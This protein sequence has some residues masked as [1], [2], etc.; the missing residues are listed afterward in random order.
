[1]LLL[2]ARNQLGAAL[3]AE[4]TGPALGAV[5]AGEIDIVFGLRYEPS[6]RTVRARDPEI[7]DLRWPGLPREA[8]QAMRG[9]LQSAARD[10][11]ELVLHTFTQRELALPDTMGFEPDE[12]RV[13]HDGVLVLFGPK[14]RP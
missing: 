12:I 10:M 9:A 5:P 4:A 14:R 2:P 11:G 3:R 13:L 7:L 6:D 8:L 1:L